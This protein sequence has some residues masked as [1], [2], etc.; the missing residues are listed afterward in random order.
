M[1]HPGLL[2]ALVSL[3]LLAAG[4]R[5]A[6]P[7]PATPAPGPL[8]IIG[9]ATSG[10]IAG[11]VELPADGPGWQTIRAGK[12]SFFGAPF[13]VDG[14]RALAARVRA[15]GLPPLYAGDIS[16]PRGGPITGGHA[17]HELGLDAD[18]YLDVEPKPALTQAQREDLEPPGL[19]RPDGRDV[20]PARWRPEHASVLRLATALPGV[21]RVLVNPAIKKH[22]CDTVTGDRSWLRLIRPW[23]GHAAHMHIHFSCPAD[24][25]ECRADPPP[26]PAGD[27]CDASL[28]WWF[29]QL[30][31]PPSPTPSRPPPP[32][33]A[34][35]RAIMALP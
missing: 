16:R 34:A 17:T 35:C 14:V 26:P 15:A 4:A 22:L 20:D 12:S 2:A 32:L 27:G 11:A 28:Q 31:K 24:Q 18:V 30:G 8:R 7:G 6:G 25:P 23:Y 13:V 33:P 10:C 9:T 19:V 29:D 3:P 5:G 21:D 1:R